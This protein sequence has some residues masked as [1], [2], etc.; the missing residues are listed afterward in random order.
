MEKL[1]AVNLGWPCWVGVVAEDLDVQD[2][3][4]RDVRGLAQ[5][6]AGAAWGQGCAGDGCRGW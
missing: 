1:V 5:L 2:R 4:Y 3:F 6:A